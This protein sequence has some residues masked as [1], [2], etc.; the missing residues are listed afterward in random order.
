MPKKCL[1]RSLVLEEDTTRHL[2]LLLQT[3]DCSIKTN[4][5]ASQSAAFAPL[6]NRLML[7]DIPGFLVPTPSCLNLNQPQST[8]LSLLLSLM[9]LLTSLNYTLPTSWRH[10]L[11]THS[12]QNSTKQCSLLAA[13]LVLDTTT[14]SIFPSNSIPWNDLATKSQHRNGVENGRG[15]C[16]RCLLDHMKRRSRRFIALYVFIAGFPVSRDAQSPHSQLINAGR[17][18]LNLLSFQEFLSQS[19]PE[20]QRQLFSRIDAIS[21]DADE[22][23]PLPL[24]H[25]YCK[26]S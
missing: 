19:K 26:R 3:F 4:Q 23:K 14:H 1:L 8:V 13:N 11:P 12:M 22:E 10:P 25:R 6:P 7:A 17:G 20:D 2:S 21:L 5:R 9:F 15:F 16:W 24:A 18:F